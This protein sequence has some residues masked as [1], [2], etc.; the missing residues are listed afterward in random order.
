M[1]SAPI[2][3]G[4]LPYRAPSSGKSRIVPCSSTPWHLPVAKFLPAGRGVIAGIAKTNGR[5]KRPNYCASRGG[6]VSLFGGQEQSAEKLNFWW[7]SRIGGGVPQVPKANYVLIS[8][9][10]S[11]W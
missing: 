5:C 6:G 10:A 9:V 11:L 2:I 4:V 1:W 7:R 3:G 8:T